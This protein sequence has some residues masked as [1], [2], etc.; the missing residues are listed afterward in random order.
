[1]SDEVDKGYVIRNGEKGPIVDSSYNGIHLSIFPNPHDSRS[2]EVHFT[3]ELEGG[4]P[5]FSH[6]LNSSI[7]DGTAEDIGEM[8]DTY[9]RRMRGGVKI[10]DMF[11][12]IEDA[13]IEAMRNMLNLPKRSQ[14]A[15]D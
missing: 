11:R 7:I 1:M 5:D 3:T 12:D 15:L 4:G 13:N 2:F 6:M 9:V 14:E 10:D 8:A